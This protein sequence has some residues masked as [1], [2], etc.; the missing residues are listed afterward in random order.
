MALPPNYNGPLTEEYLSKTLASNTIPSEYP[1]L[2]QNTVPLPTNYPIRGYVPPMPPPGAPTITGVTKGNS[3]ATISFTH[4]ASDDPSTSYSA[5]SSQ[6]NKTGTS[7]NGS[8][9]TVT[10]LTNGTSYTFTVTANNRGG[11][12]TSPPSQPVTPAT[13]PLAPTI[14]GLPTTG[15]GTVS[16]SFT[17]GANGGS[18]I[19]LYT[20]TSSQG[21]K[22]GT[23]TASP[24]TVTG[25]TNGT[26][27]TFTVTAHNS[28]GTSLPS[29]VSTAVTP[30][31]VPSA[32]IIGTTTEDGG[33]VTIN[34]TP[35]NDGGS[36]ITVYTATSSSTD[37]TLPVK[38]G[39]STTSPIKVSGLTYDKPYT[40]TLIATNSKGISLP[41]NPSP[42]VTPHRPKRFY[43]TN[44]SVDMRSKSIVLLS[45]AAS[46]Y[47]IYLDNIS[48]STKDY[49]LTNQATL[50]YQ[51]TNDKGYLFIINDNKV[52]YY[53][54]DVSNNVINNNN[55]F[56][57]FRNRKKPIAPETYMPYVED[58]TQAIVT[59][60][61]TGGTSITSL[62][63]TD[64]SLYTYNGNN[65]LFIFKDF[66]VFRTN[67]LAT[68]SVLGINNLDKKFTENNFNPLFRTTGIPIFYDNLVYYDATT[69]TTVNSLL[70]PPPPTTI[71]NSYFTAGN[72]KFFFII[73]I[74]GNPTYIVKDRANNFSVLQVKDP[75]KPYSA[76]NID[77]NNKINIKIN[78]S[79]TVVPTSA[80]FTLNINGAWNN[81]IGSLIYPTPLTPFVMP[82]RYYGLNLFIKAIDNPIM[83]QAII[84]CNL[85]IGNS[86]IQNCPQYGKNSRRIYDDAGNPTNR[87]EIIQTQNGPDTDRTSLA[88]AIK[89]DQPFKN[90]EEAR[91]N[92]D[93]TTKIRNDRIYLTNNNTNKG[94][95]TTDFIGE[96]YFKEVL[97]TAVGTK[98]DTTKLFIKHTNGIYYN[99][100]PVNNIET[101]NFKDNSNNNVKL[102]YKYEN[103]W[104]ISNTGNTHTLYVML[105]KHG[106]VSKKSIK[107]TDELKT[108]D[109]GIVG[110]SSNRGFYKTRKHKIKR[111]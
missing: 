82:S 53:I 94:I 25:L 57:K 79:P 99:F 58:T 96:V 11:D 1:S 63:D 6:G 70:S 111:T 52:P 65:R 14:T 18:A 61:V 90:A 7:T 66:R 45:F 87:G 68:F 88:Y 104:K 30:M 51:D 27:Y 5:T 71:D 105:Y 46:S 32:P 31:T 55:S 73:D 35:P 60:P 33:T 59:I 2:G 97:G 78:G 108:V 19:D 41:S 36:P 75:N 85:A 86:G 101:I 81:H 43:R 24:I 21:N 37:V 107:I 76:T 48:F 77:E 40:F 39:T 74:A 42:I 34:F 106:D 56:L 69:P 83:S 95:A 80:T 28:E 103:I 84:H 17:D 100:D 93:R 102:N 29:N 23:S 22:T 54:A 72:K 50:T 10:G 67:L 12:A 44:L 15:N 3:Q 64:A 49:Y 9:I 20:A 62:T 47:P 16:I 89:K 109:T 98:V 91:E 110:G 13:V 92:T 4:S 38:T 26:S 8:S